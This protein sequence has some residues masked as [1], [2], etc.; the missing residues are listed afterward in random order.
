MEQAHVLLVPLVLSILAEHQLQVPLVVIL[1]DAPLYNIFLQQEVVL[2]VL[3]HQTAQPGHV[4]TLL[5]LVSVQFVPPATRRILLALATQQW[6]LLQ[7]HNVV[8]LL[9]LTTYLVKPR[10]VVNATNV[11]LL[12]PQ[13]QLASSNV[14]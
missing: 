9:L 7:H 4:R 14:S 12:L 1:T 2:N 11:Y 6:H 13:L 8:V 3:S 5:V 10:K